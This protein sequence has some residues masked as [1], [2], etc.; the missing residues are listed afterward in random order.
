MTEMNEAVNEVVDT[1][2]DANVET[3]VTDGNETQTIEDV[4]KS[5]SED[6]LK[7]MRMG[8]FKVGLSYGDAVYYRNILDKSE[9][10]G[11]QQ[12]YILAIAKSEMSQ[13]CSILKDKNKESRFE[14]SLT[15][16]TI[17]S[18]GFFINRFSGKGADSAARLFSA[19]MLLR[20]VMAEINRIDEELSSRSQIE[21]K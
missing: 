11:P 6:D 21:S 7:K 9:Y 1:V 5:M 12:A 14:V 16:A 10:T 4:I 17:E 18:L 15:S 19:S 8:S 13:V 3:T 2:E 20:P